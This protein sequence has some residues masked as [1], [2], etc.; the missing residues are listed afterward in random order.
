LRVLFL[1]SDIGTYLPRHYNHGIG[2]LSAML[3]AA[4]HETGLLYLQDAPGRDRLVSDV[5]GFRPDLIAISAGTNQFHHL[6]EFAGWIKDARADIPV[7][8]G[9]NHATL[10]PEDVIRVPA[11]DYIFLGESEDALVE[12]VEALEH[13]R[14]P[15][16]IANLWGK[17]NDQVTKN[18]VRPLRE[19]LDALPFADRDIYDYQD[20]LD[21]DYYKLSLMVGRGCP[22]RC[23][24]CANYGKRELYRGKGKY[25]RTRSVDNI[26]AEI[27]E[28]VSRYRVEK[29][30]FNDDIFTLNH[31]WVQ[32]FCERYPKEFSIPFDTNVHVKTLDKEL[33]QKLKSAGCDMIRVGVE[34]GSERVR[35]HILNRPMSREKIIQ[36]FKDADEAGLRTWSFNMVGMPGETPE[37]VQATYDLN[38]QLWPDHMQV[39]VFNPYP[40]TE[41][42]EVCREKG[43]LTGREVDGYF[44]P[45]TILD[46]PQFSR[47]EIFQWHRRLIHL[48]DV[49]KNDKRLRR[50]LGERG[51][52][53]HLIDT[54][55]QAEIQTPV[56]SY[57]AE[58]YFTIGEDVRR[59]M[60][61]HPPSCIMF[62]MRLPG[63]ARL[64]FGIAVHPGVLDKPDGK[65]V[66]FTIRAGTR[67]KSMN[68]IFEHV[69]DA[70]KEAKDRGWHD[71]EI[72]LQKLSGKKVFL[73]FMTG[74][75]D[76][77][78]TD[79]NTAGWSNPVILGET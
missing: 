34:S 49:S 54:L 71:F 67:V 33:I 30:D 41:L 2:F 15:E 13:D 53:I 14:D 62:K 12:F 16:G 75:R 27:R 56:N 45:E 76:P 52:Q 73:E 22:Y 69:L 18:P 59:V 42:Y 11:I 37:D 74:T 63:K 61:E 36:V 10:A 65:G 78:R 29:L 19:D 51:T 79:F 66:M 46:M 72:P 5:E 8:C 17:R 4:G 38:E 58:D 31:E 68:I 28:M 47:D 24:Y 40:G 35:N 25:V 50:E 77:E 7:I 20:L 23:T 43:Y 9:G 55:E 6:R 70:K 44:I 32:D 39:S 57:V 64:R 1:Y 3:K 21:H 60:M 48:S 26:L